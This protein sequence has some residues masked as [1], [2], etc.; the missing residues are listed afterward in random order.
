VRFIVLAFVFIASA[1]T[2]AG[3]QLGIGKNISA[4]QKAAPAEAQ[5]SNFKTSVKK[6]AKKESDTKG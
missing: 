3:P 1:I 5:N 6:S 2:L 4:A